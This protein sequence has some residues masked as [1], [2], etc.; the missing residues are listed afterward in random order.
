MIYVQRNDSSLL[1]G[2]FNTNTGVDDISKIGK[3]RN[4]DFE[5]STN[6]FEGKCNDLSGSASDFFVPGIEKH[7]ILELFSPEMC[8]SIPMDFEREQEIM[9]IKTLKFSGGERS[10]DNGTLYAENECYCGGQCVPS[11]VFNIS[12]CRYGTP[13]FMSYPHFFGADSFYHN[14]IVGMEPV[15]EKHQFFMSF[16]PVSSIEKL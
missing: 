8:R 4:W 2:D 1:L 6:Y 12:S 15:K 13:V 10:I 7:Q 11:G 9:G 5:P 16:E 14:Q 3:I